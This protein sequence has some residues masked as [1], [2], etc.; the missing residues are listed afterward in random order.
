MPGTGKAQRGK[1]RSTVAAWLGVV[2][3]AFLAMPAS[4]AAAASASPAREQVRLDDG[5]RFH[6]GDPPGVGGR[7]DY[8]VRPEVVQ[9]AD[10]KVADARPDAAVQVAAS[11]PVLKPWILPTANPLSPI[12]HDAMRGRW[13]SRRSAT[14]LSC[15][16]ASTTAAGKR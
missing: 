1:P 8:D 14:W 9:S 5:W 10:G 15:G 16:R 11:R 6:R 13:P 4:V 3:V 2:M 12:R 7:L